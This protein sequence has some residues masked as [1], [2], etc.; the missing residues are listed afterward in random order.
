MTGDPREARARRA[1]GMTVPKFAVELARHRPVRRSMRPI[2]DVA[3]L[4]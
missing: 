3:K 2:L 1:I 4:V